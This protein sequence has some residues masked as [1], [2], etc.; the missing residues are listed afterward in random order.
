MTVFVVLHPVRIDSSHGTVSILPTADHVP[1]MIKEKGRSSLALPPAGHLEVSE[2]LLL[3][4]IKRSIHWSRIQIYNNS[5]PFVHH[6]SWKPFRLEFKTPHSLPE[7]FK[8]QFNLENV[9]PNNLQGPYNDQIP[10]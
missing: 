9:L 7:A 3:F 5:L 8:R 1:L 6:S 4:L 2:D 10:V